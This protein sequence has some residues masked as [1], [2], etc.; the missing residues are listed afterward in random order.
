MCNEY[1]DIIY[2]IKDTNNNGNRIILLK[3]KLNVKYW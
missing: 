2:F 1:N 3:T